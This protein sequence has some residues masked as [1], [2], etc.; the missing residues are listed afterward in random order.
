MTLTG[1]PLVE[2]WQCLEGNDLRHTSYHLI[3]ENLNGVAGNGELTGE[4]C[5]TV[6]SDSVES[7]NWA[8]DEEMIHGRAP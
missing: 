7:G 1:T 2:T 5:S 6:E 8:V 3:H 4:A